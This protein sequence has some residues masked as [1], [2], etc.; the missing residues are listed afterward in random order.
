M[1]R[2][3]LRPSLRSVPAVPAWRCGHA[4]ALSNLGRLD[5]AQAELRDLARDN[6]AIFPRDGDLAISMVLLAD[7]RHAVSDAEIAAQIYGLL[8]PIASGLV[9]DTGPLAMC[10]GAADRP[11]GMLAA[12]MGRWEE[13]ESRFESAIKTDTAMGA[14]PWVAW[15]KRHYAR[16]L[17]R[18]AAEGDREKALRLL[19]DALDTAQELG[20]KLL[21][22]RCLELKLELQGADISNSGASI[23]AVASL[24]YAEKPD[25][26][27]QAAPDG[28]VTPL[29]NDIEGST[30]KTEALGDQRWMEVLHE[31][32]AIIREQLAAHE[33]FE[34][35]SEGDGFMMAFQSGA[36]AG[37]DPLTTSGSDTP[38]E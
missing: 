14:R 17:A 24:V 11:I 12:T 36:V 33:G 13:A 9:V 20:M 7:V 28:T 8:G 25:L 3:R 1:R 6:F 16:M 34:V 5:E 32:N 29:F 30:A 21:T 4:S 26:R 18:R 38:T 37:V 22:D 10:Y 27:P 35:K 23:E 15:T 31:H 19:A 2:R